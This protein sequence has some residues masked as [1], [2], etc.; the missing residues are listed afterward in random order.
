MYVAACA[1]GVNS[2]KGV[3]DEPG[4]IQRARAE[5]H[6]DKLLQGDI[7]VCDGLHKL[8]ATVM[9]DEAGKALPPC[10]DDYVG[11]THVVEAS[12]NLTVLIRCGQDGFL[13]SQETSI[14][15]PPPAVVA[16]VSASSGSALGG[17]HSPRLAPEI[18]A[19]L[20]KEKEFYSQLNR[21]V[22]QYFFHLVMV[23]LPLYDL[24]YLQ[25]K[26]QLLLFLYLNLHL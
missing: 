22:D 11:V 13:K 6:L 18:F 23:Q 16:P 3:R 9:Q 4:V 26:L 20:C 21:A 12:G 5:L 15:L 10:D 25:L 1:A 17:V 14:V 2:L 19:R 24:H 7:D 8:E